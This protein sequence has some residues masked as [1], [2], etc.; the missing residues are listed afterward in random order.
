MTE[1]TNDFN[2]GL[3]RESFNCP[4][5]TRDTPFLFIMGLFDRAGRMDLSPNFLALIEQNF[6]FNFYN[7][8]L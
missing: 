3:P 4:Q 5:G 8:S 7:F 2:S 6:N 1:K